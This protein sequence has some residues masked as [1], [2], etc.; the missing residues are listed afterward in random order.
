MDSTPLHSISSVCH[1]GGEP[2]V[3]PRQLLPLDI[4]KR[5]SSEE[6]GEVYMVAYIKSNHAYWSSEQLKLLQTTKNN[7]SNSVRM[8]YDRVD[9]FGRE[10][11]LTG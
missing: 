5:P 2:V 3:C 1:P 8:G 7:Y 9:K 11:R 6:E 10:N 4:M